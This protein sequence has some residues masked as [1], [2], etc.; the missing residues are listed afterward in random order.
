MTD[1]QVYII[2]CSDDSLYTGISNDVTRRFA[3]HL[4][5]KGAKYFRGRRPKQLVYLESGHTRSSAGK[6]E[7]AIKKLPRQQKLQL[8]VADINQVSACLI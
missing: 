6:R 7:C 1:W 4:N 5:S 3:Q 2:L 8:L